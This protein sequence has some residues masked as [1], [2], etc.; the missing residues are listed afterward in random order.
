MTW[1]NVVRAQTDTY[2]ESHVESDGL[3]AFEHYRDFPPAEEQQTQPKAPIADALYSW[4]IFDLTE[5]LTITKPDTG[6]RY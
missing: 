4:G 2:F 3:G 5:P 1:E 6:D